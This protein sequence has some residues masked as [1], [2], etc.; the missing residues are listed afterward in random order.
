M[1][2]DLLRCPRC[3]EVAYR[4]ARNAYRDCCC[5]GCGCLWHVCLVH[6]VRVAGQSPGVG[7]SCTC[8]RQ[9]GR[10]RVKPT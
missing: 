2:R 1:D 4:P 5:E 3:G 7:V 10:G 8:G 9:K 6:R